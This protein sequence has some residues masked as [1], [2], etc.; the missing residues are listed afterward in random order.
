MRCAFDPRAV[1]KTGGLVTDGELTRWYKPLDSRRLESPDGMASAISSFCWVSM[2][3]RPLASRPD[4]FCCWPRTPMINGVTK[5]IRL[6]VG[7]SPT[8]RNLESVEVSSPS[9]PPPSNVDRTSTPFAAACGA[10]PVRL[11]TILPSMSLGCSA[12]TFANCREPA[13]VPATLAKPLRIAGTIA[14]MARCPMLRSRLAAEV[15]F[16]MSS[17]VRKR[18]TDATILS[19]MRAILCGAGDTQT[20]AIA[21]LSSLLDR[22]HRVKPLILRLGTSETDAHERGREAWS[23]RRHWSKFDGGPFFR[24]HQKNGLA[25]GERR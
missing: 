1:S 13:G 18:D 19:V 2:R 8:A 23:S 14:A 20:I 24:H 25:D 21:M 10:E 6:R 22:A 12:T 7:A 9:A 17:G 4:A 16:P 15:S 3:A 5:P 11:F